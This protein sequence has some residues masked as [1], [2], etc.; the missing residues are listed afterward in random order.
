MSKRFIQLL[1]LSKYLAYAFICRNFKH[2]GDGMALPLRIYPIKYLYE[3]ILLYGSLLDN[4]ILLISTLSI[5]IG[6]SYI[7]NLFLIIYSS[8]K[9]RFL[10]PFYKMQE[11]K[12]K[13]LFTS[14][15][16]S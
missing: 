12:T 15:L 16:A 13:N 8:S 11:E 9:N 2:N 4:T 10:F 3:P 1:F 5:L 6:F 7:L 14:F